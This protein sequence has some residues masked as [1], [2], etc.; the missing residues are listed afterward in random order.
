MTDNAPRIAVLGTGANGAGVG[1][2]LIRA[3]HDVTFIEQWPAH[4]D[5]MNEAGI[6]VEVMGTSEV[7]EV[8]ARHLCE[9]ATLREPFDIVFLLVKA[10]DTRWACEL[11]KPL[12]AEDGVV[13]GV[14]NGMTLADIAAVVGEDRAVGSV[15][16]I[17]ANMF[18]PGVV[19]RD[20]PREKSWFAVGGLNEV[21]QAKAARI[22]PILSAAGT[23]AV[24]DD[25]HSAKWMKL[26]VNAG[27]L[28]PSAIV[29]LAMQAAAGTP[30]MREIMIETALEAVEAAHL[31]GARLVPIF[32]LDDLNLAD[33]REFVE[34]LLDMVMDHFAIPSTLTTVLQDWMKGRHS[35]V[36]E[37]NGLV[38]RILAE[39]GRSAPYNQAAV[40]LARQIEMGTLIAS[41][42]NLTMY[43]D[44]CTG[45]VA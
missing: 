37:I 17:G 42:D 38:T 36:N 31:D 11:I 4:V 8:H 32:G 2:D 3:G 40:D 21:T 10:Y 22:A 43:Q 41:P 9:V 26:I 18:V 44:A 5:A 23:V 19:H 20:T 35:E 27:E 12:V 6:R 14:Q 7:T 13:V 15:I 28:V 30:G 39:H 16:E 1:A 24:V 45:V 34:G 29:D 25:I 33:P